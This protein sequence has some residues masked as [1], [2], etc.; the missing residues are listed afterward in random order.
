[1]EEQPQLDNTTFHPAAD[2]VV[3]ELIDAARQDHSDS[4]DVEIKSGSGGLPES[5]TATLSA[6]A[7]RPGGGV[8][9]LGL[10]EDRGFSVVRLGDPAALARALADRARKAL[11]PPLTPEIE[12][13]Q[14]EGVTLVV[15]R[16]PELP[17]A[18]KP[19]VVRR[20]GAAY[21]R[22]FD[23][24]HS[25]SDQEIEVFR[26]DRGQPTF[27]RQP[28]E[29]SSAEDL[30][31][32]LTSL[33]VAEVRNQP[34]R[35]ATM[36]DEDIL[37]HKNVIAADRSRLTLAGLYALGSYPQ[38][39]LPSLQ[40]TASVVPTETTD[41]KT[42][43]QDIAYISGALPDMLDAALP[44]IRRNTSTRV[45]FD[46]Q[47]Q[48]RSVAQYPDEAV[49]ELV[50]NAL[51]HRDLGPH[52]QSVSVNLRLDSTQMVLTNPGGLWGITV[53]QLGR[54]GGGVS[55]NPV[56]Y[57]I[58]KFLR[59]RSG[60]RVIEGIGSGIAA[61]RRAL[62]DA[63]M[64]PP[65]F[66]DSGVRFTV[67]VPR[68]TL[69]DPADLQWISDLPESRQLTDSQKHALVVMRRGGEW[70]NHG[71]RTQ[72]ALDSVEA[73]RELLG[74]VQAGL[75]LAEGD[76]RGRIYR[77]ADSPPRAHSQAAN[78][79]LP[80]SAVT[81]NGEAVLRALEAGAATVA[82]LEART[83]LSKRQITYALEKLRESGHVVLIGNPGDRG[84]QYRLFSAN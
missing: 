22:G 51:V 65:K 81:R 60:A 14:F 32:T 64:T 11:D 70:T 20:T 10:A 21:V 58:C 19:C 38:R 13:V 4:T 57:E 52:V 61:A 23:G 18:L 27:D 35:L 82:Q 33:F 77:L 2:E 29:G 83:K 79:S 31:S 72:F 25:I 36:S 80:A 39:L 71:Y 53:E 54:T 15:A 37:F 76:G 73:R 66:I 7:N 68:H 75:A 45:V 49:R 8:I 1:M 44:W 55:R 6:F 56:L 59:T 12:L 26:S 74:L 30:D 34:S 9:I 84:S 78:R 47:G 17:A 41:P 42:R 43:S 50:A 28:V 46:G 3:N 62:L 16:V 63:G 69:L 40:I 5:L 24:D 48:G 67:L